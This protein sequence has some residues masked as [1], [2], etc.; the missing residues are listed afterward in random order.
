[1]DHMANKTEKQLAYDAGRAV[2]TEPPERRNA[3]ACPFPL[4]SEE[5]EAWLDGF[6]DALDED[7]LDPAAL[8][9]QIKEAR[10]V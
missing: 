3:D 8:R 10:D 9:K 2:L 1:M 5:R 4:G 6:A 7:T